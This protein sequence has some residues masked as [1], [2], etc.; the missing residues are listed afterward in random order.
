MGEFGQV[1]KTE[2]DVTGKPTNKQKTRVRER[3]KR[4]GKNEHTRDNITIILN[5]NRIVVGRG[6]MAQTER[7]T[8]K[9]DR[10]TTGSVTRRRRDSGENGRLVVDHILSKSALTSDSN[11]ERVAKAFAGGNRARRRG[12]RNSSAGENDAI[13]ELECDGGQIKAEIETGNCDSTA[14]GWHGARSE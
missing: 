11:T 2:A 6:K 12:I 4:C 1:P 3:D 9:G 8:E 7:R 14:S 5:K 10:I 13:V